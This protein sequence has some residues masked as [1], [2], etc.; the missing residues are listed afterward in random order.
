MQK[1]CPPRNTQNKVCADGVETDG[2]AH[3]FWE[4]WGCWS[5][6]DGVPQAGWT[7]FSRPGTVMGKQGGPCWHLR[8]RHTP[9]GGV[10]QEQAELPGDTFKPQCHPRWVA[11]VPGKSA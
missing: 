6:M 2:F 1:N 8:N 3:P 7:P 4:L 5:N 9:T 11:A 10:A